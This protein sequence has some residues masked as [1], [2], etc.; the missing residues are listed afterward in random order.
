MKYGLQLYSVRD[1]TNTQMDRVLCE[2][3]KMGY[4]YAEF[5]GFFD[6]SAEQIKQMLDK[7]SLEVCS[8]HTGWTELSDETFEKTVAYH[9]YIG[10]KNIIIPGADLS[11]QEKLDRFIEFVNRVQPRL[12][13]EGIALH[14]HNHSREFVTTDYGKIIHNE[15]E[16]HTNLK[17]EIDTYWCYHAGCDPIETIT[18]LKDRIDFIHIKDGMRDGAG[19]PL[20][21]GEAPVAE[22]YKTAKEL[23]FTMVVES[24]T[25]TPSGLDEARICMDYLKKAEK[26]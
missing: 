1:I 23:G 18:R 9:K 21:L 11:T 20:G 12:E 19:K 4:S 17:F 25:L 5:A 26:I 14:Y 6:Y 7:Y 13:K 10:N 15:L 16:K 24:E 2:I 8:T 3:S 22:V